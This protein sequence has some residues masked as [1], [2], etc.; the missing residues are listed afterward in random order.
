M[1]NSTRRYYRRYRDFE[2]CWNVD[3]IKADFCPLYA[4]SVLDIKLQDGEHDSPVLNTECIACGFA[5]QRGSEMLSECSVMGFSLE[6]Q[7]PA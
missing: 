2:P 1:W 6:Y 3:L 7:G 4:N 5:S